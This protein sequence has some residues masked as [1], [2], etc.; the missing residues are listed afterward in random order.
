MGAASFQT[1]YVARD[2]ATAFANAASDARFEHGHGG[3]TGTLAEKDGFLAPIAL[4]ARWKVQD[5]VDAVMRA[6][7][8]ADPESVY[9]GYKPTAKERALLAR[10][11]RDLPSWRR[12]VD[13]ATG[14]KWGPAVCVEVTG[15]QAATI[16]K[17][18][19]RAGTRDR[20]YVFFGLASC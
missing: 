5:F 6:E 13:A 18:Q 11:V 15:S 20:V 19:G 8:I 10:L 12:I 3:Y 14:D 7:I 2:A 9:G 4:P 1:T 16:K 17:Q